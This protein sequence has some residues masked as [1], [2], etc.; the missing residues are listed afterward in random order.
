MDETTIEQWSR[1]FVKTLYSEF[2]TLENLG[3][4]IVILMDNVHC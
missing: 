4:S 2:T 3:Y 1:P